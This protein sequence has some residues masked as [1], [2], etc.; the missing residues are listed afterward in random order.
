MCVRIDKCKNSTFLIISEAYSEPNQISKLNLFVK[1]VYGF[2]T[3]TS[4]V[5][6][7]VLDVILGSEY[8]PETLIF[9]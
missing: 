9:I 1:L 6:S 7:F 3:L 2:K 8:D 4:F 5:K